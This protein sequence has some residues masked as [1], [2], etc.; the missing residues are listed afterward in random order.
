MHDFRDNEVLLP[1]GYDVIVIPPL[2]AVQAFF[3]DGLWKSNHDL[4]SEF[5]INFLS[6][7]H[8]FWDN[9]VLLQDGYD[10]IG[11]S[12]PVGASGDFPWRI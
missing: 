5:Y 3:H 1:T 4:L 10:V 6:G 11:I 12:P 9:E 2:G 7:M 8:G